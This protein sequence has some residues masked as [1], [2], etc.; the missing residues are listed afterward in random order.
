MN[1]RWVMMAGETG[2]RCAPPEKERQAPMSAGRTSKRRWVTGGAGTGAALVRGLLAD[3]LRVRVLDSLLKGDAGIR[4]L[5]TNPDFELIRGD[6]R[7]LEPVVRAVQGVD[8][9]IHLAERPGGLPRRDQKAAIEINV[10]ATSLLTEVCRG[11]GVA[12]L[13]LASTLEVYGRRE[14]RWMKHRRRSRKSLFAATKV[15]AERL[16]LAAGDGGLHPVV[17]RLGEVFGADVHADFER[18]LN[19]M[20]ALAWRRGRIAD[21][22]GARPIYR[23]HVGDVCAVLRQ[24]LVCRAEI[25]AGTDFQRRLRPNAA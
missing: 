11:T 7:S 16:V 1:E 3:G 4:A 23:T 14:R 10:A 12:R 15:D 17:F 9:V 18:G 22:A 13:A 20:A 19:R 25:I 6:V 24:A 2:M 5:Y 8:A 21:R